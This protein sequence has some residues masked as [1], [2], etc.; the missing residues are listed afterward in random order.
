MRDPVEHLTM[1]LVPMVVE[2]TSRGERAYDIFSRMLKERIIFLTGPVEDGMASLICAQLLFLES[3]NP[4]KEIAMYINSP[5]GVVTSGFSIY[6][7]MQYIKCPVSTVCMGMAASMGSFLL[8]AGEKGQRIALPNARIMVHQP[9]GGFRGQASDIERHAED[10]IKT[11]R[12]LN[13]LYSKHT[14]QP[15]EVIERTLDR[16]YFMSAEEAKAFGLIDHVY[17]R[18]EENPAPITPAQDDKKA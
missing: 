3:E 1:N 8:T 12:Q 14:G 13:E 16:D 4:K 17:E 18:R 5:G 6:D 9:S 2:Q 10:I 15:I 11:K 7:T